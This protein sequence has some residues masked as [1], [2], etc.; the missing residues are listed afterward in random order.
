M[1]TAPAPD[2]AEPGLDLPDGDL[3]D[4][5]TLRD[6]LPGLPVALD[7]A[8]M[9]PRL[10]A[11]LIGPAYA[12]VDCR[13]GTVWY[14]PDG[15]CDLRYA[16]R[17]GHRASGAIE[18]ATVLAR[19]LPTS[20]AVD[21]YLRT[22]IDPLVPA[23]RH[24][25]GPFAA[26]AG[27]AADLRLAVHV[28]PLD[29][30]LPTLAAATDPSQV[31]AALPGAFGS[32]TPAGPVEVVRH[33]RTGRC[34]LRFPRNGGR[35]VYGK[36]H[37][38]ATG[39]TVHRLLGA[40]HPAVAGELR[41]PR[42][43]GYASALRTALCETVPGRPVDPT[44]PGDPLTGVLAA[45]RAAA[46]LHAVPLPAAVT[47]PL[48]AQLTALRAELA[49]IRPLWPQVAARLDSELAEL[50]GVAVATAAL[51]PRFS[52]GDLT[53]SQV[54]IDS[55]G[56]RCGV[57]D[58]DAAAA[59]EPAADLGR[60]RCY[61]RLALAR[62]GSAAGPGLADTFLEAYL[63]YAEP[64]GTTT[65]TARVALYER[66]NLVHVAVR[67]CRQLKSRRLRA[68]LSLLNEEVPRP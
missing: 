24:H 66:L 39:A 18:P 44:I 3:R 64:T 2:R 63:R 41:V 62:A 58:F 30:A 32:G 45:A 59:A 21:E 19:M 17:L 28:F 47:P 68:A 31:L 35:C 5:P 9:G 1:T 33:S 55:V 60:F 54:L 34:V 52:H 15:G 22:E 29:P 65:I 40:L 67:A 8:A 14:R 23:R 11:L 13:P 36:V 20:A 51:P 37:S 48:A 61:L 6:R 26:A 10:Q 42:P 50:R 16:V 7:P 12:L 49:V 4:S 25:P 57:V 38:D 46:V 56:G 53:P 27:A 43:L